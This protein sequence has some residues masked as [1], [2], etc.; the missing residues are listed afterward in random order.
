MQK[1]KTGPSFYAP[2]PKVVDSSADILSRDEYF[3]TRKSVVPIALSREQNETI[4]HEA[5]RRMWRSE[6]DQEVCV[7]CNRWINLSSLRIWDS[8][9]K[10]EHTT[11]IIV[12]MK[13]R[14]S[15]KE[16]PIEIPCDLRAFYRIALYD[17]PS[18]PFYQFQDVILSPS[19]RFL[20]QKFIFFMHLKVAF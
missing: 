17:N 19:P 5:E 10:D 18:F 13:E 1:K 9:S 7:V 6:V 2:M 14:L 15:V 3:S 16:L 11:K 8:H 20:F 4:I 12:S